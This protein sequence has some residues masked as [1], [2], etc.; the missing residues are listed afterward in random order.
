MPARG[1]AGAPAGKP[2]G[3]DRRQRAALL[4][5]FTRSL[6]KEIRRGGSVQLVYVGKGAEDQ[7]EGALRFFLSP[8]SA[9]V[10][11]QVLRLAASS[12][13]VKDWSRPSA[14]SA[15]WSPGPRGASARPSPRPSPGTV[16]RWCCWTCPRPRTPSKP[17]P[18]A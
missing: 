16:R 7:L 4:E 15:R 2:Q 9:Y 11:A 13:Q 12:A 17:W 3:P 10:S 1:G 14:A 8:K 18:P 5:G 6:G